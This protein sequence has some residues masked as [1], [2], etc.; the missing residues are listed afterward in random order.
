MLSDVLITIASC[1]IMRVDRCSALGHNDIPDMKMVT[2][3]SDVAFR[4]VQNH[5][6][7]LKY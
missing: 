4:A 7:N 2:V 1:S 3:T 6:N 5:T